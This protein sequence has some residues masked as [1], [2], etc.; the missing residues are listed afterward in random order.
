MLL[1]EF[2]WAGTFIRPTSDVTFLSTNTKYLRCL[3][4]PV[5]QNF[6]VKICEGFMRL[7][8]PMLECASPCRDG[9]LHDDMDIV[10]FMVSLRVNI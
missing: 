5:L 7:E 4:E 10:I 6:R 2:K 3:D 9:A 1:E 8:H